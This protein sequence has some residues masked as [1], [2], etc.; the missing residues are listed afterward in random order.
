MYDRTSVDH[1]IEVIFPIIDHEKF[2]QRACEAHFKGEDCAVHGNSWKQCYSE[3]YIK[4]MISNYNPEK[5]DSIEEVI[6]YFEFMKFQIFNLEIPTFSS[7]F[8]ISK[9]PQY[10]VNLTSLELKYSPILADFKKEDILRRKLTRKI[11]SNF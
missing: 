1:P 9:I 10:F 7:D 3:N 6:K 2:W 5:G 11:I 8:D 4:K